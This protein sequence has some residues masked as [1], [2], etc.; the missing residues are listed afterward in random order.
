MPPK[1]PIGTKKRTTSPIIIND[2][3]TGG[4]DPSVNPVTEFAAVAIDPETF[5]EIARCEVMFKPHFHPEL[6]IYDAKALEVTHISMEMLEKEGL[7]FPEAFAKIIEFLKISNICTWGVASKNRES[8]RKH[9]EAVSKGKK[10][11]T[12]KPK[13]L[14]SKNQA[15]MSGHN[16]LFDHGFWQQIF[17]VADYLGILEYHYDD[18]FAGQYDL[19]GNFIPE[20]IDT[21]PLAKTYF[22]DKDTKDHKLGTFASALQVE[23]MGAHRAINDVLSSTDIYRNIANKIRNN[24]QA[25]EIV[26]IRKEFKF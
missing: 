3:E 8:M 25:G 4:T 26:R 6:N 7:P 24:N 21:F 12:D 22:S 15:V 9:E 18:F 10:L 2:F 23:L 13:L 17:F 20:M 14:S 16:I 11:A 5:Q 19:Y 1:Q